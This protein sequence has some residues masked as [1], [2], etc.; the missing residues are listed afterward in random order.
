MQNKLFVFF[1]KAELAQNIMLQVV[2]DVLVQL[3]DD[4]DL[5]PDIAT[6]I[7]NWERDYWYTAYSGDPDAGWKAPTTDAAQITE[8]SLGGI[9]M[10]AANLNLQL[11]RDGKGV[12]LPLA[13]QDMSQLSRIP[14][15]MPV[16]IEIKPVTSLPILS[17]LRQKLQDISA[18]PSVAS[19][20]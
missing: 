10:N 12:P 11:K 15:F 2:N 18:P 16:I 19:A 3:E 20:T 4:E 8:S 17:E 13:Q 7:Y 14:G 9:D 1:P 5:Q 6:K